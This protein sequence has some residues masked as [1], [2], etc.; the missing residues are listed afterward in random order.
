MA[1]IPLWM[2]L[3]ERGGVTPDNLLDMFS[4]EV[5][6]V[7]VVGMA[8]GLGIEVYNRENAGWDGALSI[9]QEEF[10]ARIFVE[11]NHSNT[12]QRFTIAHELG[13]LLLHPD[14]YIHRDTKRQIHSSSYKERE[15]N[16]FAA[17]L[18]MPR[19]MVTFA[20]DHLAQSPEALAGLFDVSPEAMSIRM[21]KLNLIRLY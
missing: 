20:F 4:I 12:R 5:P 14:T 2:E 16:Q 9:D 13:H 15:A 6:P 1:D 10:T 11:A 18:L 8:K 19:W 17:E 7:P 21:R 3:R